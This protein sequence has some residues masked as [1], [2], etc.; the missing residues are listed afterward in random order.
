MKILLDLFPAH[1]AVAPETY[2]DDFTSETSG[3]GVHYVATTRTLIVENDRGE[4]VV[5]V[6]QDAPNGAQ[7]IFR[8]KLLDY[9]KATNSK[10][11]HRAITLSGKRLAFSKDS[12]CGCGS[13]LKSWNAYKT[14][15]S[16]QD[17]F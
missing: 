3:K 11:E 13:R 8:E 14:L 16:I 7:I 17:T 5:V 9:T 15:H 4:L 2:V 12:N 6:A 10:G 1:L